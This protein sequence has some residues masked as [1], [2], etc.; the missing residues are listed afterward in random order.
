MYGV[1]ISSGV[2]ENKIFVQIPPNSGSDLVIAANSVAG[3]FNIDVSVG[4][5]VEGGVGISGFDQYWVV[6]RLN[7][8]GDLENCYAYA[9]NAHM[10]TANRVA[11]YIANPTSSSATIVA[12]WLSVWVTGS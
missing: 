9:N 2:Q 4:A 11:C 1:T 8:E 10:T 5:N 3:P 6:D 12:D 7:Y